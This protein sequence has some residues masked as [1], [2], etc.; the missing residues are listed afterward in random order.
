MSL[1]LFILLVSGLILT[2]C[3]G[4]DEGEELKNGEEEPQARDHI[5][6]V[7][8]E[9][10]SLEQAKEII[11]RLG[12]TEESGLFTGDPLG[13]SIFSPPGKTTDEMIEEFQAEPQVLIATTDFSVVES[14]V[15]DVNFVPGKIVVSFYPYA[16]NEQIEEIIARHNCTPG[17]IY[18]GAGNASVFIKLPE[19]KDEGQ[20]IEEFKEEPLVQEAKREEIVKEL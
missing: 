9:D 12:Y 6:V 16:T 8:Q 10:V 19:G 14:A 18:R 15:P 3:G 7:F 2:G 4:K 5:I 1:F 20:A 13:V 17:T 11:A